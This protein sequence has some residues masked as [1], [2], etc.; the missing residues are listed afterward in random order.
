MEEMFTASRDQH[1]GSISYAITKTGTAPGG[2]HGTVVHVRVVAH[3]GIERHQHEFGFHLPPGNG[4]PISFE[5]TITAAN[6]PPP[7]PPE[8]D[9]QRRER[10][11]R[12]VLDRATVGAATRDDTVAALLA[13]LDG[14]LEAQDDNYDPVEDDD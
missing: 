12:E 2:A 11:V 8:T 3:R 6:F 7:P 9:R 4:A 13:V 14:E 10:L 5:T 1:G